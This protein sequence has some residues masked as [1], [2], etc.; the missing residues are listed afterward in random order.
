MDVIT[1]IR[2]EPVVAD[3]IEQPVSGEVIRKV[4]LAGHKAQTYQNFHAWRFIVVRDLDKLRS[5]SECSQYAGHIAEAAFIVVPVAEEMDDL[6]EGQ[7]FAYMQLAAWD[8]SI[9]SCLAPVI[10]PE[11]FRLLLHI[12][13]NLVFNMA[14]SFGLLSRQPAKKTH[15]RSP[16]VEDVVRWE[17]W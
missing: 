4:I 13:Q 14:I 8:L 16:S 6:L 15:S 3:F 2:T 7:I 12:P 17:H 5:L 9:G 1:A 10:N 11:R